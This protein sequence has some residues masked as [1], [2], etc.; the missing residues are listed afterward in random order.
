MTT[1]ATSRPSALRLLP[2]IDMALGVWLLASPYLLGFTLVEAA[3][4]NNG[5]FGPF[6]LWIAIARLAA[7]DRARWVSWFNVALGILVAASPFLFGFAD[8]LKPMI[9][10]IVVGLIVAL[11][12]LVST[13]R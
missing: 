5:A 9:N 11:V 2:V 12:A 13:R 6:I 8:Q 10:N 1:Q 3:R 7:Q 4:I